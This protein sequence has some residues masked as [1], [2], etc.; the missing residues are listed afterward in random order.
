MHPDLEQAIGFHESIVAEGGKA[1]VG[2]DTAKARIENEAEVDAI[3]TE[4]TSQR[5]KYE[6]ARVIGGAGIPAA[7]VRDT[8]ELLSDPDF[9]KRGIMQT[10]QHP[11]NGPFKMPGW[12]VRKDGEVR[13]LA[14]APLL[15]QHSAEALKDWLGM[16]DAQVE[17]LRADKII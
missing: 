1:L 10:V 9:E 2:Y 17:A 11:T 14:P 4:W 3:L 7:P 6:A 5:D 12:A 13:K 15:G 8:L 16:S